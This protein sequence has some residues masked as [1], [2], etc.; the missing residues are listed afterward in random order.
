MKPG[1]VVCGHGTS[2]ASFNRLVGQV[3]S[4]VIRVK[5]RTTHWY[6]CTAYARGN[7]YIICRVTLSVLLTGA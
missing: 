2:V 6:H 4:D 7:S 5:A 1:F 3:S